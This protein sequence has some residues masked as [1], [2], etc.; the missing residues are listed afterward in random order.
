[1]D[2]L[3]G[4][5]IGAWIG[6]QSKGK[7]AKALFQ[8][9]Q[10]SVHQLQ[11]SEISTRTQDP[12]QSCQATSLL[13]AQHFGMWGFMEQTRRTMR[14]HRGNLSF[15]HIQTTEEVLRGQ[16]TAK[17]V[18][19]SC[20]WMTICC[21]GTQNDSYSAMRWIYRPLIWCVYVCELHAWSGGYLGKSCREVLARSIKLRLQ[22]TWYQKLPT[23]SS[24]RFSAS[25]LLLTWGDNFSHEFCHLVSLKISTPSGSLSSASTSVCVCVCVFVCVNVQSSA[26]ASGREQ[27]LSVFPACPCCKRKE[28][29][30]QAT[31]NQAY[32]YPDWAAEDTIKT[33]RWCHVCLFDLCTCMYSWTLH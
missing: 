1:M 22:E 14:K 33:S 31:A 2:V 21:T 10:F 12:R 16:Q 18:H 6:L 25:N 19:C 17:L 7:I 32:S 27:G 30:V 15:R 13:N 3:F 29:A 4:F 11:M 23:I 5:E 8:R 28:S 26:A 20:V 9:P 24:R